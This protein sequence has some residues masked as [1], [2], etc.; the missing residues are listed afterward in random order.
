MAII[1]KYILIK[2]T[3]LKKGFKGNIV[4][5]AF[6]V[7]LFSKLIGNKLP[8]NGALILF[9]EYKFHYPAYLNLSIIIGGKISSIS[10]ST[11]TISLNLYAKYEKD[12][13]I[14]S[15]GKSIVRFK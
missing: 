2:N 11:S 15:T 13:K 9:S 3:Q 12:G 1:I 7:S 10:K 5:G 14:I 8:G 6:I 4:H